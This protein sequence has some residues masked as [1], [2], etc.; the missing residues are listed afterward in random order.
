MD[1][2]CERVRDWL[3]RAE[4]PG[5][6]AD[7]PEGVSAHVREC[8]ECQS[9]IGRLERL[10]QKWRDQPVPASAHQLRD[11]FIQRLNPP[12]EPRR[13]V[14]H[15]FAPA[16]SAIAAS[17]LLTIGLTVWLLSDTSKA[18]ADSEVLAQLIDWNMDLSEAASPE[19][20]QEIFA[21]RADALKADLSRSRLSGD[22]RTFA[23]QL[24]DNG[25]WLAANEEP[26]EEADR[27]DAVADQLLAR[28]ES[29]AQRSDS[30]ATEKL[31]RQYNRVAT[32]GIDA[33]LDRVKAPGD[34]VKQAKLDKILAR[35][36][37][38]L[39]QLEKLHEAAKD[40]TKKELKKLID[41]SQQ[42]KKHKPKQGKKS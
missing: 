13:P 4:R 7:A 10:E 12:V 26:L 18:H 34:G 15:W 35:D 6:L 9:L 30:A 42:K 19:E 2:I 37:K 5:R 20:R 1:M 28:V 24:L 23:E 39:Q 11:S 32:Q 38:R 27:F 16:A 31:A 33:K 25:A 29:A 14:R 22:D 36:A 41:H 40:P 8:P 17:L 21:R 3:L